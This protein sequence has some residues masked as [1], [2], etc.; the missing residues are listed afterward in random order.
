[1][2]DSLHFSLISPE[3]VLIDC[4]ASMVVI[5]GVEGEFGILPNHAPL[6]TLLGPGVVTIYQNDEIFTKIFVDGGFAEVTP[7]KCVALVT[8]GTPLDSLN[9]TSLEMEIQNLLDNRTS[10]VTPEERQKADRR[11]AIARAKLMQ[12]ISR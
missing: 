3:R 2:M 9:K 8:A 7:E 12:L 1:M 6:M 4:P 11:L 5:P 10:S